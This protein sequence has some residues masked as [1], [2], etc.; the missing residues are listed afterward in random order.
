[1]NILDHIEDGHLRIIVKPNSSKTEI[2]CY[3]KAKGAIRVNIKAPPDKGK[4]NKELIRF[5]SKKL[6]MKIEI[7]SGLT[8][9]TKVLKIS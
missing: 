3:D 8:S 2:M 6:N 7:K 4:A 9:R 5:L 1:M